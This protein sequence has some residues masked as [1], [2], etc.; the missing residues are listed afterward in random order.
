MKDNTP[1]ALKEVLEWKDACYREVAHLPR[2]A[3]L[4]KQFE[5][6]ETLNLRN[7]R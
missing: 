2:K 4:R 3:A 5:N 1:H 6:D 7:L